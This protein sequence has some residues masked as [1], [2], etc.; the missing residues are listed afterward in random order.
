MGEVP[1]MALEEGQAARILTGGML[2]QGADC[3]V[4]VEYSALPGA[5]L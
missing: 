1:N 3:V 4:M 5:A 2:P